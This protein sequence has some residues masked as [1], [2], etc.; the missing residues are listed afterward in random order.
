MKKSIVSTIMAMIMVYSVFACLCVNAEG[1][2]DINIIPVVN[3]SSNASSYVNFVSSEPWDRISNSAETVD[4]KTYIKYT[5]A[6][7]YSGGSN[8][9]HFC[10]PTIQNLGISTSDYAGAVVYLKTTNI[11]KIAIIAGDAGLASGSTIYLYDINGNS[12]SS[13]SNPTQSTSNW[14]WWFD[15]P[16]NFEGYVYIP[17]DAA[18]AAGKTEVGFI[19]MSMD[20]IGG[21]NG[22][23]YV[24]GVYA[25]ADTVVP[26]VE[27]D[28]IILQDPVVNISTVLKPSDNTADYG[29]FEAGEPWGEVKS[30]LT[31][32][33]GKDYVQLNS[34]SNSAY[35]CGGKYVGFNLINL[36][37]STSD[38]AGAIVYAKT[39][40]VER[41]SF[42]T[43]DHVKSVK[44]YDVNAENAQWVTAVSSEQNTDNWRWWI[45][46]PQ[47]FEGYI[48]ISFDSAVAKGS[49]AVSN[50][51]IGTYCVGGQY[52][53][54]NIGNVYTADVEP[55][56]DSTM[57]MKDDVNGDFEIDVRDLVRLKKN[58]AN[59]SADSASDL[60]N[61]GS[62]NAI[63]LAFL[64]KILLGIA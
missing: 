24:G 47:N 35:V 9:D 4:G 1:S 16:A 33:D 14:R 63:D 52:G 5:S 40:N 18:I 39:T 53:T 38:N 6:S 21:S 32:I 8:S 31:S 34:T 50:I 37:L 3:P 27:S 61:D 58:I 59:Q 30:T 25:T 45:N 29:T 15:F 22:D 41:M 28:V 23:V 10:G 26:G 54:F 64:R 49:E 2:N 36:N 46:I 62:V 11:G 51:L 44:L 57:A 20:N 19:A 60:N 43:T 13:L 7:G 55:G 12:W 48:Y 17:F 56:I 42:S